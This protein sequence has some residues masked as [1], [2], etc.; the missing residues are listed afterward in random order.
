[1]GRLVDPT[2]DE[3]AVVL[4]VEAFDQTPETVALIAKA[5]GAGKS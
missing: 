2:S 4:K 5:T 3:A 1:M